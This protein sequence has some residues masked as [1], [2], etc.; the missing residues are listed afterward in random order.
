MA[1]PKYGDS[2]MP[3]NRFKYGDDLSAY[4]TQ[5]SPAD[6]PASST[7]ETVDP[8]YK[9]TVFESMSND[10]FIDFLVDKAGPEMDF[11][12]QFQKAKHFTD[13]HRERYAAYESQPQWKKDVARS[14][15]VQ[16][17]Y[18][19]LPEAGGFKKFMALAQDIKTRITGSE[20]DKYLSELFDKTKHEQLGA[21]AI[22]ELQEKYDIKE[23]PGKEPGDLIFD[24]AVHEGFKQV[25]SGYDWT[26]RS[27]RDLI[28]KEFEQGTATDDL[29]SEDAK[30][31]MRIGDA[32]M[33]KLLDPTQSYQ[34][35]TYLMGK[36]EK[37]I[38]DF[39]QMGPQLLG[40]VAAGSIGG[41][42]GGALFM[43]P[44]IYGA[45]YRRVRELGGTVEDAVFSGLIDGALQGSLESLSMGFALRGVPKKWLGNRFFKSVADRVAAGGSE[46]VTE[47]VQS[48]IDDF[49]EAIGDPGFK[50]KFQSKDWAGKVKLIKERMG[51]ASAAG[52]HEGLVAGLWG[53]V[54]GGA[55]ADSEVSR[56][57]GKEVDAR[58]QERMGT[59]VSEDILSRAGKVAKA[60]PQ[61]VKVSADA[62]EILDNA[63]TIVEGETAKAETA[64]RM[65]AMPTDR[66]IEAPE[67]LGQPIVEGEPVMAAT[68]AGIATEGELEV[69]PEAA[70]PM[71]ARERFPGTIWDLK[72]AE[73]PTPGGPVLPPEIEALKDT[74]P[75]AYQLAVDI[76][77]T[78]ETP[79]TK[80]A[81][82]PK[83]KEAPALLK[84]K[85]KLSSRDKIERL[86]SRIDE[87][88]RSKVKDLYDGKIGDMDDYTTYQMMA[89]DLVSKGVDIA[90]QSRPTLAEWRVNPQVRPAG[91]QKGI[92]KKVYMPGETGRTAKQ[93][94][95]GID[96]AYGTTFGEA[97]YNEELK[98]AE[99]R[100]VERKVE[101]K[102]VAPREARTS[103]KQAPVKREPAKEGKTSTAI[104]EKFV[105]R[106][107]SK[108]E[109][110]ELRGI[111]ASEIKQVT[112]LTKVQQAVNQIS[113][114]LYGTP[115]AYYN[116]SNPVLD[117]SNGY[118]ME[119]AGQLLNA[120]K[121]EGA[122]LALFGHE[123]WHDMS[124]N[125]PVLAAAVKKIFWQNVNK[126]E[127]KDYIDTL[128]AARYEVGL[129]DLDEAGMKEEFEADFISSKWADPE[130]L[131]KLIDALN[132]KNPGLAL[133][134]FNLL[135]K[136][137]AK[138]KAAIQAELWTY[139]RKDVE[140]VENVLID[141]YVKLS[142]KNKAK[143]PLAAVDAITI[144]M[145]IDVGKVEAIRTPASMHTPS[146]K[147]YEGAMHSVAFEKMEAEHGDVNYVLEVEDG[148]MTT[149]ERFVDR[150]E[151]NAIAENA[152]Q[153]SKDRE[154][155]YLI[156]EDLI[157]D[158]SDTYIIDGDGH[159][160]AMAHVKGD[161]AAL[162]MID[163]IVKGHD[164]LLA[165]DSDG[166]GV[167]AESLGFELESEV[168]GRQIYKYKGE[169]YD[170]NIIAG[171][172]A[173]TWNKDLRADERTATLL[174]A[175]TEQARTE[176]SRVVGGK[177]GK[178]EEKLIEY[179]NRSW[180]SYAAGEKVTGTTDVPTKNVRV[181]GGKSTMAMIQ[182]SSL[183]G[184]EQATARGDKYFDLLY[185]KVEGYERPTDFWEVPTWMAHG[186][187]SFKNADAYI[188]R[189]V[190]EAKAYLRNSG[191]ESIMFSAMDANKHFI[192]ELAGSFSGDI[193]IG[194]YVDPGYFAGIKNI[195]FAD[196][197]EAAAKL[198]KVPFKQGVDY[199]Q[200]K[201]TRVI[202]R[203][204]MSKGCKHKCAFCTVPKKIE[205]ADDIADQVKSMAGL[206]HKLIYLN[207]KT[208]GQA[209]NYKDLVKINEQ[210]KAQNPEFQGFI[211]Q[212]TAPAFNKMDDEFI[213]ESGIKYVE[214]GMESFNDDILE[215][216]NKPHRQKHIVEAAD[217]I[218]RLGLR[219]IPNVMVGLAGVDKKGDLWT[220]TAESYRN[221]LTFLEQNKDIISHT[222][223]YIL[224]TYE[225]TE[226]GKQ[227]GT[228]N[229][230]DGDENVVQKSWLQNREL[231]DIFYRR[232]LE[233]SE[234]QIEQP[235]V[236]ASILVARKE[237]PVVLPG[238]IQ[239]DPD[240]VDMD[241]RDID[242]EYAYAAIKMVH[243]LEL[244]SQAYKKIPDDKHDAFSKHYQKQTDSEL[245]VYS[246][247]VIGYLK[248][249][250]KDWLSRHRGPEGWFKS[251]FMEEY[252]YG[253][254][255]SQYFTNE[256]IGFIKMGD[257]WEFDVS[258][259]IID[260]VEEKATRPYVPQERDELIEFFKDELDIE[261][262]DLALKEYDDDMLL[263]K[264]EEM[265]YNKYP[266]W[267][268]WPDTVELS[269]IKGLLNLDG[270]D[271]PFGKIV[272]EVM[273]TKGWEAWRA[274]FPSMG[275][276]EVR[277]EE[278]YK[279]L[280]DAKDQA[281]KMTAISLAL[282]E[283]H[284]YGTMSEHAGLANTELQEI[285][286][287]ADGVYKFEDM[288]RR[289]YK[290]GEGEAQLKQS[291]DL[292][293][294]LSGKA[295]KVKVAGK[296]YVVNEQRQSIEKLLEITGG[297]ASLKK[298]LTDNGVDKIQA[299]RIQA[300]AKSMEE[301]PFP[302]PEE[303]ATAL[304]AFDK[305]N[306][307]VKGWY[308]NI[309]YLRTVFE[310]D[311]DLNLFIGLAMLSHTS[312]NKG[313]LAN[314]G[315]FIKFRM[316]QRA[317]QVDKK[318]KF[319]LVDQATVDRV[320]SAESIDEMFNIDFTALQFKKGEVKVKA[321]AETFAAIMRDPESRNAIESVVDIWVGRYF[322]PS[323]TSGGVVDTSDTVMAM[324]PVQ[325]LL[326]QRHMRDTEAIMTEKS[327]IT[328]HPDMA[329]AVLWFYIRK[330]WEDV[331]GDKTGQKGYTFDET[332]NVYA[333]R[334]S[335]ALDLDDRQVEAYIKYKL[336]DPDVRHILDLYSQDKDL[337]VFDMV[338]ADEP[339]ILQLF[340][341]A[342]LPKDYDISGKTRHRV[343][344]ETNKIYDAD[345]DPDGLID[346]GFDPNDITT[347][348]DFE[349]RLRDAGWV[350][351]RS[352]EMTILLEPV[353]TEAMKTGALAISPMV[354]PEVVEIFK[355]NF[356]DKYRKMI[357][358]QKWYDDGNIEALDNAMRSELTRVF[359]NP[360]I[361]IRSIGPAEGRWSGGREYAPRVDLDY[362]NIDIAKGLLAQFLKDNGQYEG[363][364]SERV[365]GWNDKQRPKGIAKDQAP[366][367]ML[368]FK[369]PLTE[370]QVSEIVETLDNSGI[371]GS[372]YS[373]EINALTIHHLKYRH[374]EKTVGPAL[375]LDGNII[376]GTK[377]DDGKL[378]AKSYEGLYKKAGT[379]FKK[380][381]EAGG[382]KGFITNF[383]NFVNNQK[384]KELKANFGKVKQKD[385]DFLKSVIDAVRAIQ[386]KFNE[387]EG[388]GQVWY[389]HH[390]LENNWLKNRKGQE[391]DKS[392]EKARQVS[393]NMG[394]IA[395]PKVV[396]GKY[397]KGTEL[398]K[399]QEGYRI[400]EG[401]KISSESVK[402]IK[403]FIKAEPIEGLI[404]ANQAAQ[405][406]T[407]IASGINI[408]PA[409]MKQLEKFD[410]GEVKPIAG[411]QAGLFAS[412]PMDRAAAYKAGEAYAKAPN[413]L[414][415][416]SKDPFVQKGFYDQNY[417]Y[418]AEVEVTY[419]KT[420]L[421]PETKWRDKIRGLNMKQALERARRN[422]EGATIKFI[423]GYKV[424]DRKQDVM[425]SVTVYHGTGTEFKQYDLSYMS[426]GEGF[427]A[428][429]WGQYFTYSKRI[430]RDYAEKLSK[431][432]KLGTLQINL[433]PI[434]PANEYHPGVSVDYELVKDG[435]W[436]KPKF[437]KVN[438]NDDGSIK[439][440]IGPDGESTSVEFARNFVHR[441]VKAYMENKMLLAVNNGTKID[442]DKLLDY[443]S[444][445]FVE[446]SSDIED[447]RE[448]IHSEYMRTKRMPFI[449]KLKEKLN[450]GDSETSSNAAAAINKFDEKHYNEFMDQ[451][452]DIKGLGKMNDIML[453]D[454]SSE[455]D[456]WEDV[457]ANSREYMEM[458][459][460]IKVVYVTELHDDLKFLDWYKTMKRED[461]KKVISSLRESPDVDLLL[462]DSLN[463][464]LTEG[465][466]APLVKNVYGELQALLGS[467]KAAS[468]ALEQ[469]GFDGIR[470]EANSL[471]GGMP[472]AVEFEQDLVMEELVRYKSL[473]P[474]RLRDV[475]FTM[476]KIIDHD[477]EIVEQ[478]KEH[479]DPEMID[480]LHEVIETEW[481][482][483]YVL[484][485]K[486]EDPKYAT[487]TDK[488]YLSLDAFRVQEQGAVQYLNS[489]VGKS[490]T[491]LT[492]K[493]NSTFGYFTGVGEDRSNWRYLMFDKLD[494][495]GQWF[496]H[497]SHAYMKARGVPG[498]VGSLAAFLEHGKLYW[499]KTMTLGV[500]KDPATKQIS[501]KKGFI[502]W[503][504]AL[505][506]NDGVKF[507]Y[508][509][510]A[511][512]A[513]A[514]DAEGREHWL[515]APDRA[516]IL[517]WVGVPEN[518]RGLSWEEINTEF[519]AFNK[520][521]L[522]IAEKA[523][524]VS[525]AS[526]ADWESD[527]YIPFY[528]VIE[529]PVTAAEFWRTPPR[530]KDFLSAGIKRLTGGESKI[531]DPM[532]NIMK[533][534]THLLNTSITNVARGSSV[535]YAVD[536]KVM[537]GMTKLM[538]VNEF[539]VFNPVTGTTLDVFDTRKEAQEYI[540]DEITSN[541]L[542][543]KKDIKIVKHTSEV[544]VPIPVIEEVPWSQTVVMKAQKDKKGKATG[545]IYIHKK[546][547]EQLLGYQKAGKMQYFK[548][549]DPELYVAISGMNPHQFDNAV[550][551]FFRT[552]KRWLTYG[553]TF[554]PGFKIANAVRDTL[555]TSL[556]S[557]S[558]IPFVDTMRGFWKAWAQ[559]EAYVS[560]L[561]SGH[562][563][564]GDYIKS[565][566]PA[567]LAKYIKK[568]LKG[569]NFAD[570]FIN[571][572]T[573]TEGKTIIGR[574]LDTPGKMLDFWERLGSAS[575]S[576]ARV[577]LAENLKAKGESTA[578]AY[579]A[580]RDL[581]DFQMSG[582]A[583]IVQFL[584]QTIPFLNARA[585]G[586]YKMGR[587]VKEN[588]SHFAMKAFAIALASLGLWLIYKDDD[589]YKELEDWDRFAYYH[590]WVGD[591][592]FRVPKPFETGVLFSTS[593]E[594]AGNV[595]V[596]N[597][598]LDHL[599]T[600]MKHAT[601]E[602]FAFNPILGIQ[603]VKP[604]AEQWANKV[605][606]TGRPIEGQGLSGLR[607]GER[608]DPWTSETMRLIG[609]TLNL[610]PKRM[611][612]L[613]RGYTGTFGMFI[614]GGADLFTRNVFDF[615]ERPAMTWN[616]MPG[617]T[618]FIKS[619]E[620][621]N[622][623]YMTRFYDHYNEM[624]KLVRTVNYYDKLGDM[625]MVRKLVRDNKEF[626]ALKKEFNKARSSLVKINRDIR[627][628]WLNNRMG[629]DEKRRRIEV[630]YGKRNKIVRSIY[631][632]YK[633]R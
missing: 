64:E 257:F 490:D 572:L 593:V 566:D 413:N 533:N 318:S 444:D 480:R 606:F 614:L 35:N 151:G 385:V 30:A 456:A 329:Q 96:V 597:E 145:S 472:K 133:N 589:R 357:R 431:G 46:M 248:S 65:A 457:F 152:N 584:I 621:R 415:G 429:G 487:I 470:Y 421:A 34:E 449:K 260:A 269:D 610:P 518:K 588:P 208:F 368:K 334:W 147:I 294:A 542:F 221:T 465:M 190:E 630:L 459:G 609:G 552:S 58:V 90:V 319:G 220:E 252:D 407:W 184:R 110:K 344:I 562:A 122:L 616:E 24:Q 162:G 327:G 370:E 394:L 73:K 611:E 128:S 545:A 586:L 503:V 434:A 181:K 439:S 454:I 59:A 367:I 414:L 598:D 484:F 174:D 624:S 255:P 245:G 613:V 275:A 224:A 273:E 175:I 126:Q 384:A 272:R 426:T 502:P 473:L 498:A 1:D 125:E 461:I 524:V 464:R 259:D 499:D 450:L 481:G 265:V 149:F 440:I 308:D 538:K 82:A 234:R 264:A 360:L 101:G 214:L 592:H 306:P 298:F 282:N 458:T 103:R 127:W 199:R 191:Y 92:G 283:S 510:I 144:K 452:F 554:G 317:G 529:N 383:G 612:H 189:N 615:P 106:I 406:R 307:D 482:K 84:E 4:K 512:R 45:K 266:A 107:S 563:F 583:G 218:R 442:E 18:N 194:G 378:D 14:Q 620:A 571:S 217:K 61:E 447:A 67:G 617:L 400:G 201:G 332:L 374:R 362:A 215:K 618:R 628:V 291:L 238:E 438:A 558:F 422:W 77:K 172:F 521:I 320:L 479:I 335:G 582:A 108:G 396:S 119:G 57:F 292:K 507:F 629:S 581:M 513:D 354:S 43:F 460:G 471:Y 148:Y 393:R 303:T 301:Y 496:G 286:N 159:I 485:Y 112:K 280:K 109:A 312:R 48:F 223:S 41:F 62:R 565:E 98:L 171:R 263:D 380:L 88:Q 169:I 100:Q 509:L 16:D 183:R 546:T 462:L 373:Q 247:R 99:S 180:K 157:K 543:K 432:G 436:V 535:K 453:S 356:P 299:G 250:Y 287:I 136:A 205:M 343:V 500:Q 600:Y 203:L 313:T 76:A 21:A 251:M 474:P 237:D 475:H 85:G 607:W 75:D 595:M 325:H 139:L 541:D 576:A 267:Y 451:V 209:E 557:K 395:E 94:N 288:L 477:P 196:S 363:V 392:I 590:F 381:R 337:N 455:V 40:Q 397:R 165:Y 585:Q 526:R 10:Q 304:L 229:E 347:L 130:F 326:V 243:Y 469:A 371:P 519:Q 353:R 173:A 116:T 539:S 342:K 633:E 219:F 331:R 527:L 143:I 240:T 185:S 115:V 56:R 166:L 160:V 202:P 466:V 379:T 170:A 161:D 352:G 316:L 305:K 412:V 351:L 27:V 551:E 399:G 369:K 186:A 504:K 258:K 416:F 198:L 118:Y 17:L 78:K 71:A 435:E 253:M 476:S 80:E 310:N 478:V 95:R 382:E 580:S 361:D 142:E 6:A 570:K 233:F 497:D 525:K 314:M 366:S 574:I 83:A 493:L 428:F 105:A 36:T 49:T 104:F 52:V 68:D 443:L 532:E 227:L 187:K 270:W 437:Y 81:P 372:V 261:L 32:Y 114:V 97:A 117:A 560:Y 60:V 37:F 625:T 137:L 506:P 176:G 349:K 418:I 441:Y 578:K 463:T 141:F 596:G 244:K 340:D 564:G 236:K 276:T 230:I 321:F 297:A 279:R 404:D 89:A 132:K 69:E 55:H 420:D 601:T 495:I 9:P 197:M 44:Q 448:H 483:N 508:W 156:S 568:Q 235:D 111:K 5:P 211:I 364:L 242:E 548:V 53:M 12:M 627:L 150:D 155:S 281:A 86:W 31:Q 561:A 241:P 42:A 517:A 13:S 277:V 348:M 8:N 409:R 516:K 239:E 38:N 164:S 605:S 520:N 604:L 594:A 3:V 386:A 15:G 608:Y 515:K 569:Q 70:A 345:A 505:G 375:M 226:T 120:K 2:A 511:K 579:F 346:K 26:A 492:E 405:Y 322:F 158:I 200:F 193:I 430:A 311:D 446:L 486:T 39:V 302:S 178:A 28:V 599:W 210:V 339:L 134:L 293:K 402:L 225:G 377:K 129:G 408:G 74:D 228:D 419:P 338:K 121:P 192:K 222:N 631:S 632:K 29:I 284:V 11:E 188:V 163:A 207:D 123:S 102:P 22:A 300:I 467:K 547:G 51:S 567:V 20:Q 19:I 330:Q 47:Y 388:L 138:I 522:D 212:T 602:T 389:N 536:N 7:G 575:E 249:V 359:A 489:K 488:V 87:T 410:A 135:N 501:R 323:K 153:V 350:G 491:S 623:K 398:F 113:I 146:G 33:D 254:E 315:E 531:G 626:Y 355:N 549:N 232:L 622:T 177:Q 573:G 427:Q 25:Q 66:A 246:D 603:S 553:A 365:S 423:K 278:Q 256:K 559:N 290:P 213:K 206:G 619:G 544:E 179:L 262:S 528:R 274:N 216:I 289:Q 445:S 530:S 50:E 131:N 168:D 401:R 167:I 195:K 54:L 523:G 271:S 182:V 390:I 468:I 296:T 79:K 358:Y 425:G 204:E 154:R 424:T 387:Y 537:T 591:L 72:G 285:N 140:A 514:L 63:V 309:S 91:V 540:R 295:I 587:A 433:P 391:Y 555:H 417:S 341:A 124:V 231:H 403:E 376:Y 494:P 577:Q 328:W 333:E 336:R 550:M 556:I 268:F 324:S 534:W 411:E 23:F 93:I